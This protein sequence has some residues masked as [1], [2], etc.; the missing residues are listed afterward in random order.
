MIR[1]VVDAIFDDPS[2]RSGLRPARSGPG[3]LD[4][5]WRWSTSSR[6]DPCST[7]VAARHV[8]LH[9]RP[10]G[11]SRSPR[12]IPRRRCSR[13]P[14]P[15]PAPTRCDGCMG[16]PRHCRRATGRCRLHDR[17]RRSG[18][19]HRR[20]WAATLARRNRRCVRVAGWCSRL[21]CRRARLGAV[22]ARA[23]ADCRR[24]A[25]RRNR[26][27]LGGG[28]RRTA[29]LV[30]FRSMTAF[31][32]DDVVVESVSTLRFRIGRD[33][34]VAGRQRIR[35]RR[36]PRCSRSPRPRVRLR[37]SPPFMIG[38]G[39][40]TWFTWLSC[41]AEGGRVAELPS[42]T[43]TFLFT[44]LEG[45]TRL[46]GGASRRDAAAL[47]RHD[48]ILRDAIE[49]HDGYVVKTTGDGFHAVFAHRRTTRCDAARRRAARARRP[50]RGT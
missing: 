5:Y 49:A 28:H 1:E 12:W 25:R 35:A 39:P 45:S 26:G 14:A 21:A 32:R 24:R 9:A 13:W 33:R 36:D 6:P 29:D 46:V 4:V 23:H 27:V 42:G 2:A 44:D 7:S 17:K 22:D 43:V 30:T 16:T 41:A 3:D 10:D 37:C 40:R 11:A 31:L 19:S 15:S 50:R 34:G 47:A 38:V 8:R 18:V 20:R 48:A